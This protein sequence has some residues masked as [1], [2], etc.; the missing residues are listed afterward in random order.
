MKLKKGLLAETIDNCIRLYDE[1]GFP[2]VEVYLRLD[3]HGNP[4][5]D[6]SIVEKMADKICEIDFNL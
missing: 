3:E 1:E 2:V 6:D 5:D 4:I